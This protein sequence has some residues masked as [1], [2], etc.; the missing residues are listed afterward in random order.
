M[1]LPKML[2]NSEATKERLNQIELPHMV[3]LTEFVRKLRSRMGS[4]STIPYFDP[5]DGGI[6]AEVLFLLEAPGPKA[7]DSGF[8][9]RNNPDE[10]AKNFYE[11][12]VEAGIDRKRTAVWNV[13]PWYI[14]SG[15]RIRAANSSDIEEGIQ[16]LGE[17]I[18]L[19]P[20]LRAIVLVGRKA[21]R[22]KSTIA[23]VAP[24][25]TVFSCPHPSPLFVN[26]RTANRG[27]ILAE[28]CR[29][30]SFLDEHDVH[31]R[32]AY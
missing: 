12:N 27:L 3:P 6:N 9:S 10:T 32:P 5:W 16:S 2:G 22:A 29:V 17:L 18:R 28:L 24:R 20:K 4:D 15:S 23:N 13:V 21:Q 30:Q 19:L 1:D 11:L 26:R 8:I 31:E 7:R 25:L 14:G